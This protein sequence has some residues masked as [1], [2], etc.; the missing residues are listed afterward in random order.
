MQLLGI[1]CISIFLHF[2][3]HLSQSNSFVCMYVV[4]TSPLF[5]DNFISTACKHPL[6]ITIK[7]LT[8]PAANLPKKS[9]CFLMYRYYYFHFCTCN[10]P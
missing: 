10:S 3:F 1:L 5:S 7:I 2:Y 4:Y 6:T 9:K 8:S